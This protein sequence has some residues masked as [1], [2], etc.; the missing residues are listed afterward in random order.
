MKRPVGSSGV[1]DMRIIGFLAI[2]C[3]GY[4]RL[5][6]DAP[7]PAQE[8]IEWS[9]IWLHQA[10]Q[11]DLPQ[12]LLIGDSITRAY[13]PAVEKL[14]AGRAHVSRL[15]N[16]R[17]VGDPVLLEEIEAVLGRHHFAVIHFNNGM[18]GWGNSDSFYGDHFAEYL[19]TLRRLS[20]GAKLIW[21]TTTPVR[22]VGNLSQ[23]DPKTERVTTRNGMAARLVGAAGISTDDVFGLVLNEPSYW[24]EKGGGVHF[25]EAGK[26]A[27]AAQVAAAVSRF[28]P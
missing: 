17:C 16:S 3:W 12:V 11:T 5:A 7:V 8:P 15:C 26:A 25:G 6:A 2:V 1:I 20:Q 4:G 18:H 19:A 22:V 28:L 14:L 13:Y 9:D 23:F 27:Q 24:D 10:D 21:A